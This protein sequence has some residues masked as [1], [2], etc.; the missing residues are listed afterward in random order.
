MLA[1]TDRKPTSAASNTKAFALLSRCSFL[2]K[3]PSTK[4]RDKRQDEN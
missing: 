4:A 3:R 2:P 1:A